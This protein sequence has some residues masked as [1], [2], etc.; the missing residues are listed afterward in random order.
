MH[1]MIQSFLE[2]LGYGE[3]FLS[4]IPR[5]AS[6]R[7]YFRIEGKGKLLMVSPSSEKPEQFI[8]IGKLLESIHLSSPKFFEISEKTISM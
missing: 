2:P 5:D 6:K 8:R 3:A 7:Q 4:P 1:Q